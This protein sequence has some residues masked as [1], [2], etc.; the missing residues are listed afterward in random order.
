MNLN[1]IEKVHELA[2]DGDV[3]GTYVAQ[4]REHQPVPSPFDD[5][6]GETLHKL[7]TCKTEPIRKTRLLRR[8][9]E[10]ESRRVARPDICAGGPR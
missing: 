9:D 10:P 6:S 1:V 3:Y 2:G 5:R 4:S 7:N 8:L